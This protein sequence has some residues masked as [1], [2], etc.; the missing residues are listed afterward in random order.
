[1]NSFQEGSK[2]CKKKSS[3]LEEILGLLSGSLPDDQE[4]S[5]VCPAFIKY[6]SGL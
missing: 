4:G 6:L 3:V 2:F 5:H 1:M